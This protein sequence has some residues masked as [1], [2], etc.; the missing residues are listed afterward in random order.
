MAQ[1]KSSKWQLRWRCGRWWWKVFKLLL[2][3]PLVIG[4]LLAVVVVSRAIT[5]STPA[6]SFEVL[7]NAHTLGVED[8]KKMERAQRLAGALKITTVSYE[9]GKQNFTE[10]FR[11]HEYL[12]KGIPINFLK[13]VSPKFK[14]L[15]SRFYLSIDSS[16]SCNTF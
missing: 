13:S 1:T 4:L 5:I 15:D 9:P 7:N 16:L 14:P 11:L 2:K 6:P 12:E 3:I 10:F 8:G